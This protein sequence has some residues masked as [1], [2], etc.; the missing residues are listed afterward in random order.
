MGGK[1]GKDNGDGNDD[2]DGVGSHV[3][4]DGDGDNN[5]PNN[6]LGEYSH[7]NSASH[8]MMK[9]YSMTDVDDA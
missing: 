5:R 2:D 7:D 9:L 3:D 4:D 6:E 1:N 8:D